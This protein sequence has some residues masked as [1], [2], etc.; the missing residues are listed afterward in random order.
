MWKGELKPILG[1]F[2]E[3]KGTGKENCG[4]QLPLKSNKPLGQ[5]FVW[6]SHI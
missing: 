6:W 1:Q 4:H 5:S 3:L 2:L